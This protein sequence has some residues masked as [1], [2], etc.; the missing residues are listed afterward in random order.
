MNNV[1]DLGLDDKSPADTRF[2]QMLLEQIDQRLDRP[3]PYRSPWA[4]LFTFGKDAEADAG[5]FL[6]EDKSLLFVL[7]ETPKGDKGSF[8]IIHLG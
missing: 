3:T 2:L 5:Y 8:M 4:T 1:F 6:S 7:V